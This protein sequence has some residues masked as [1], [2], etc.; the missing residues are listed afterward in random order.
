MELLRRTLPP[1]LAKVTDQTD[2]AR[3]AWLIG[4]HAFQTLAKSGI[5]VPECAGRVLPVGGGASASVA[6]A[7]ET[8]PFVAMVAGTME[9]GRSSRPH[10][11]RLPARGWA[12]RPTSTRPASSRAG[13]R[14]ASR[15]T[16]APCRRKCA[17]TTS[18]ACRIPRA[19]IPVRRP[20]RGCISAVTPTAS[21]GAYAGKT[22]ARSMA[23]TV[24]AEGREVGRCAPRS[25]WRIAR[26]AWRCCAARCR[27]ATRSWREGGPR[28]VVGL[29]FGPAGA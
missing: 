5:G 12:T 3:V 13:P 19:A 14:S 27:P 25:R 4:E 18:V 9:A 2:E 26:S 15:S 23:R 20:S 17:T 22:P 8:A 29:P 11:S 16:S 24:V 10:V 21:C 1:R 7:P 6:L 28:L